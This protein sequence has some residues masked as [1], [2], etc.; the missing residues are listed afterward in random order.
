V[1][2]DAHT[3][4][5]SLSA[6]RSFTTAYG[7]EGSLCIYRSR[8]LLPSHRAPTEDEWEEVG[9][10]HD[11][12]PV[13]G[14]AESTRDHPGFDRMVVLAI[15]PQYLDGQLIGT[16]DTDGVTDVPGPPNPEKCN[17]YIAAVVRSAP[18]R[19]IGF[20]S[21]NPRYRGVRYAVDELERSVVELGLTGVKLYPMYQH[22]APNDREIGFPVFEKAAE[23]GI[24]VMVH[25]AGSTRIDAKMELGRPALLDDIGREFR[26]LR[27][28]IAHCGT[29]WVKEA[30]FL[31]TKHPNFYADLSYHI[32]TVSRGDLFHWLSSLED[33]FVPL[34][35]LFFGS[36]YPGFL[37][38]P[39]ALREKLLT[40]N[41]EAGHQGRAPIPQPRLEAIMGDNIARV[42][43]LEPTTAT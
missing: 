5:L 14:P 13:I 15:S 9:F 26:D 23:L 35:K 11:G 18:G 37:Y 32:A 16:V 7:R 33:F 41:E 40:V 21:V 28:I 22:W 43:R 31:L 17:D 42:L 19:F 27:L 34:E 20:G 4:I 39:V 12:F 30:M 24:P 38:D 36:D 8:G 1:Q 29:P 25:Q 6:D 3:H 10:H 2:I